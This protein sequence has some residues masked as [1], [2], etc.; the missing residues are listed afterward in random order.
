[1]RPHLIV[2]SPLLATGSCFPARLSET[3]PPPI[4]GHPMKHRRA[5][6][7]ARWI[8]IAAAAT[9]CVVA[10]GYLALRFARPV[11][12]VSEAVEA[13]V[14]QAFYSTGTIQ[15]EREYPIKSNVAGNLTAVHVDKGDRVK[16]GQPLAFVADPELKYAADKARAEL[17]ERQKRADPKSSPVLRE[18]QARIEASQDILDIAKREERRVS[19]LIPRNA[20]SQT[21]LDKALDRLKFAW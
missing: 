13:P 2:S 15:P 1:M 14:V 3:F 12:T 8:V 6:S 20:A 17:V 9:F 21:D 11:V 16:K 19:E 10:A 7:T 18:F 4:I 5:Q